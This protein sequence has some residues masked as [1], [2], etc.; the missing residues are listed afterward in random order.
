[1]SQPI[2]AG[3]ELRIPGSVSNLGPG[4]DTLSVAVQVY[5][6][7]RVAGI[8]PEAPDTIET[9]FAGAAPG[10]DNRIE[11]AFRHARARIGRPTPGVRL[12]VRS[13]IPTRAGLGSSGAATV[14]GLRLYEQ[15]TA[16]IPV[17]QL[18]ALASDVEGHP[19]NAAASHLGGLTVSCQQDD[20]QVLAR[21]WA[22]P[23]DIQ[24]V[25]AT[26]DAELETAHARRV[27]PT[28]ITMRDAIFN[29]QRALQLVHALGS[30]QYGDLRE[31][32]RDRWHQP[33]RA[34]L[35]PGLS[36]ALELRDEAVLGACLSG[37]GPSIVMF[38]A[39]RAAEARTRLGDIYQRLG[40]ASTIRVLAAHQPAVS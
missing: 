23:A 6:H 38:T 3:H 4:F 30:G 27:L 18:L 24:I 16:P 1:M 39:G 15:L 22:W 17:E 20:G 14:A 37:A 2:V 10:G 35:V 28:E 26:P 21:S 8:R 34:V 25:V 12:E 7:V 13:E 29:L 19:D 9:T 33:A 32:L 31:A 5:L 11:T 40:M 36:D